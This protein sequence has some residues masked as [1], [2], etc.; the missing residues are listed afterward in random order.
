MSHASANVAGKAPSFRVVYSVA[1][2]WL[3]PVL[4]LLP[5]LAGLPLL[6]GARDSSTLLYFC[7]A[8]APISLLVVMVA[9]GIQTVR[10]HPLA[11]WTPYVAFLAQSA[12]FFGFGP[13]VYVFGSEEAIARLSA[14]RLALTHVELAR[15]N[16]LVAVGIGFAFLGFGAYAMLSRRERIP[17]GQLASRSLP[18]PQVAVLFLTLGA[19]LRYGLLLPNE[20]GITD[21]IVPGTVTSA[22]NLFALGLAVTGYLAVL[23]GGRWR[24][25]FWSLLLPNL[26]AAVLQFS[27]TAAIINLLVPAFGSYLAHRRL[28]RLVLWVLAS[29]VL[30]AA[31]QPLVDYG[32][33][34]IQAETGEIGRASIAR[35]VDIAVEFARGT[36]A[37]HFAE[38]DQAAWTRLAY[39]GPQAYAMSLHDSGILGTSLQNA[40]LL[41]I[42]RFVWPEKPVVLGPG[43][44]F[45]EV[46][47]G[48]RGTF[49]GL[50]VYGDAYW[51]AGWTGVAIF[52]MLMG[53]LFGWFSSNALK[54]MSAGA[55]LYLPV[56]LLGL[57]AS[58]LGPT[59][60]LVN[61]VLGPLP[62]YLGYM[63]LLAAIFRLRPRARHADGIR[64]PG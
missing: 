22:G 58:L 8:A 10:R 64:A 59:R 46:V 34:V 31:M 37:D 53:M 62:I 4:C 27:K 24:L 28:P 52:S 55:L 42:P 26:F 36:R 33:G 54:W 47:T 41:F 51:Q 61:G 6:L 48:R 7:N 35:R 11:L 9:A 43:A 25:L 2:W 12:L 29:A 18:L 21:F 14:S 40:W 17:P 5:L 57:E 56:V 45:Y 16:L 60:Y 30:F 32:R 13:L 20:F 50:S 44:E 1:A 3:L 38:R 49:L 39:A 15:T 23:R 63:L 19:L